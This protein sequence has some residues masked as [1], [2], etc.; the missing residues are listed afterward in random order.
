MVFF[1]FY[2]EGVARAPLGRIGH[3]SANRAGRALKA[4]DI[5][6]TSKKLA[7]KKKMLRRLLHTTSYPLVSPCEMNQN[8]MWRRRRAKIQ[9]N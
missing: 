1:F 2:T 7:I 6:L 5:V 3:I 8:N 4:G 9:P